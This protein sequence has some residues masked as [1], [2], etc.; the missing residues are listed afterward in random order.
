MTEDG[1]KYEEAIKMFIEKGNLQ[2][3]SESY[4][5]FISDLS[6]DCD[7]SERYDLDDRLLLNTIVIA[8]K[9]SYT[10]KRMKLDYLAVL[11]NINTDKMIDAFGKQ[12]SVFDGKVI[13][14]S[15]PICYLD[16][17]V[18]TPYIHG[19]GIPIAIQE[20][21]IIPYSPAHI[22]EIGQTSDKDIVREEI[23]LVSKQTDNQEILFRDND[24]VVFQEHPRICY[25]RTYDGTGDVDLA[26]ED[27]ILN[28][29]LEDVLFDGYRTDKLRNTYNS[30]D[31]D[32]FLLNHR[33][34]VDKIL[35][36][37]NVSYNLKYI[38]ENGNCND[39]NVLNGF[40]HNLYQVMDICGFKKDNNEHKIRSSRIDI[41]HLLY[42]S[43]S[44][45]FLTKDR[46]LRVRA[47][48][49]YETLGKGI[50]CPDI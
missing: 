16:Q 31:P 24:F 27:K 33:E 50:K 49:I 44:S 26:K 45:F 43:V 47:R 9:H 35:E 28:D 4:E 37:M 20:H 36:K 41:E 30:Q 14:I 40:I 10:Q 5:Y 6:N 46:K 32:H 17:N 11:K 1:K 3:L 21:C 38:E 15:G 18:F 8:L 29:R 34:L 42:G 25:K 13:N 12:K 48:N 2:K 22:L 39:Y 7:S 19:E 23:A